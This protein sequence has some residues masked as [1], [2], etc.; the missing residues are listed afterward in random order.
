V[1]GLYKSA[2]SNSLQERL[3]A[4]GPTAVVSSDIIVI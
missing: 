4:D 3:I 2:E 1:A